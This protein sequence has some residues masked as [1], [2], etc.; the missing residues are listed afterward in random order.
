MTTQHIPTLAEALRIHRSPWGPADNKTKV[1][2]QLVIAFYH[3]TFRFHLPRISRSG[4]GTC[5]GD[6]AEVEKLEFL[7]DEAIGDSVG[8]IVTQL[9]PD[10]SPHIYTVR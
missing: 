1:F 8:D 7:G 3:P 9:R 6:N 10:G 2:Y 5:I 4:W